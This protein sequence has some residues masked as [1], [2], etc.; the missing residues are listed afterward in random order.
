MKSKIDEENNVSSTEEFLEIFKKKRGEK[1]EDKINE[2]NENS[3]IDI[4]LKRKQFSSL[5]KSIT[6]AKK[7]EK[8]SVRETKTKKQINHN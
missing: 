6:T 7:P 8:K 2:F 4:N 3:K 1:F 5:I